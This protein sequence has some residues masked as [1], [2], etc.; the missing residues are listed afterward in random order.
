MSIKIAATVVT[1]NRLELLKKLIG[2]LRNQTA[3]ISKIIVIN[4]SST[5]GTE[6]WLNLQTD[7]L[8]IK[9]YNSGSSGGQFTALQTAYKLGFDLIWAMDD[10]VEPTSDCL[11][12][13]LKYQNNNSTYFPIRQSL[14][15]TIF[16]SE[17]KIINLTNP[18]KSIWT[19]I[20]D[21]N[22]IKNEL[23]EV[24]GP[25]FEGPLIS[26][27]LIEK[28]GLPAKDFFIFADDT[29]YFI[30]AKRNG[31]KNIIVTSSILKR[32]LPI[33]EDTNS[34]TWK[35]FFVIRNLIAIDVMYGNITVRFFRP[36]GYLIK[37]LSRASNFD[38]IKISLKAFC[39]GYFYK[40]KNE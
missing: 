10:D 32:Q 3:D 4:N 40:M 12:N 36:L 22:D 8:V 1:Y 27:K 25:T 30:R 23:I 39:K 2:A 20:I 29:E 38:D 6:D 16:L 19:K 34:F 18:F 31:F 14:D 11:E 26:K 28:I 21:E 9:Q 7:L 17:T 15:G 37:F 5:D 13:L 35:H 24:D 33:P